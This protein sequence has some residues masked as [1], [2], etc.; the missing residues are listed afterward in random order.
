M[1]DP[2]LYV[3]AMVSAASVSALC[4]LAM[5]ATRR[6]ARDAWLNSAC[7]SGIGFGLAVGYYV[8]SLHLAWPPANALDRFL[9]IVIPVALGIELLAG[10]PCV[11]SWGAWFLRIGLTATMPRILLHGSV[12]LSGYDSDWPLWR[13]NTALAVCAVLLTGVWAL[14]ALLSKRSPG[15]SISLALCLTIQCAGLTVMMAG[16]IKGGAAALP[17]VATLMATTIAARLISKRF[18]TVANDRVLAITGIGVVGLFGLLFIGH[19]FGRLSTGSALTMLLAP[20]LCW[21]TEMP[22]LRNRKP[23][24]VGS[25]RL[26]LVA[27]P[28]AVLLGLAKRDFERDMVPLLGTDVRPPVMIQIVAE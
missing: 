9:T 2:L 16:Y 22:L 1:P 20:L 24:L 5:V 7:V 21:A 10:F 28:L 19:F 27:I 3:Q 18:G 11:P 23:W 13:T 8:L 26:V 14:L 17:L 25:L 6:T 4:M 15:V 12:Y